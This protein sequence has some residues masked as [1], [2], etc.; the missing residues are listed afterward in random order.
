MGCPWTLESAVRAATGRALRLACARSASSRLKSSRGTPFTLATVPSPQWAPKL[1]RLTSIAPAE[2]ASPNPRCDRGGF[3]CHRLWLT[4]TRVG[5]E[6]LKLQTEFMGPGSVRK[7]EARSVEGREIGEIPVRKDPVSQEDGRNR[8]PGEK[9]N[10]GPIDVGDAQTCARSERWRRQWRRSSDGCLSIPVRL[11][12]SHK[13]A[14]ER[15][16]RNGLPERGPSPSFGNLKRPR[17]YRG[18]SSACPDATAE[19]PTTDVLGWSF[20]SRRWDASGERNR[21]CEYGQGLKF[22]GQPLMI[23][24][25]GQR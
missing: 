12:G 17:D 11:L 10:A 7:A 6:D 2:S 24:V 22:H 21:D 20:K 25:S 9:V 18:S 14:S 3:S 15:D 4:K 16:N 8:D 23:D 13:D 19:R 5:T 1:G